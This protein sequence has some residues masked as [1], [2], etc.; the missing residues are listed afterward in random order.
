MADGD[1]QVEWCLVKHVRFPIPWDTVMGRYPSEI[2]A[3]NA[4]NAVMLRPQWVT[5]YAVEKRVKGG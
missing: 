3:V 2:D 1:Q 4:L 5:S